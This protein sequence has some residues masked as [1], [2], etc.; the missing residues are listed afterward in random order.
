MEIGIT[1]TIALVGILLF[2]VLGLGI[3]LKLTDFKRI[4]EQTKLTILGSFSQIIFMSFVALILVN[5]L[6]LSPEVAIGMLI[7]SV[8]LG[9][10]TSNVFSHI[11][12]CD[13]ALSIILTAISFF[14]TPFTIFISLNLFLWIFV[15]EKNEMTSFPVLSSFVQILA[16]TI[17]PISTGMLMHIRWPHF[18][19][20]LEKP[21]RQMAS[22]LLAFVVGMLVFRERYIFLKNMEEAGA[23]V[24]VY[25]FICIT[26]ATLLAMLWRLQPKQQLTIGIEVGIQNYFFAILIAI[27]PSMLNNTD[28]ALYPARY[29]ILMYLMILFYIWK[30]KRL[31]SNLQIITYSG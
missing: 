5:V 11:P 29:G 3:S 22:L 23:M 4:F 8:Y 16:T 18:C 25:G 2:I 19:K 21:I 15:Q 7:V 1:F 20:N 6:P 26:A 24:F 31:Y 17:I 14:I 10:P 12:K 9:G 13:T 28:Y 30:F 27:L